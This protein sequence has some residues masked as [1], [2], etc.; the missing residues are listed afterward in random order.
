MCWCA[1][2]REAVLS[3]ARVR[4]SLRHPP[5][6]PRPGLRQGPG[7]GAAQGDQRVRLPLFHAPFFSLRSSAK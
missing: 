4:G 1:S 7:P 5:A 6:G 3:A 2:N